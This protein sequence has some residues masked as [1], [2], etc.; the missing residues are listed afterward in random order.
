[1]LRFLDLHLPILL[2]LRMSFLSNNQHPSPNLFFILQQ[3]L[4]SPFPIPSTPIQHRLL[5]FTIPSLSDVRRCSVTPSAFHTQRTRGM[6]VKEEEP[7]AQR[8]GSSSLTDQPVFVVLGRR[9]SNEER[10]LCQI[11]LPCPQAD[12]TVTYPTVGLGDT[13]CVNANGLGLY[14]DHTRCTGER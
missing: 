6:A 11:C 12:T 9:R 3:P 2:S 1:M 5:L 10:Q 13:F 7:S 14:N 4:Y 8:G